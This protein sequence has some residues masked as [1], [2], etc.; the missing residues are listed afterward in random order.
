MGQRNPQRYRQGSSHAPARRADSGQAADKMGS[1]RRLVACSCIRH[2]LREFFQLTTPD[3]VDISVVTFPGDGGSDADNINRWRQQIGAAPTEE[4]RLSVVIPL[5]CRRKIFPR[6][7]SPETRRVCWPRGRGTTAEHGFSNSPV[8]A[9]AVEK[10][11]SNFVKFIQSV[12][13]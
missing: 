9:A 7:T 1:A 12:R 5:K 11:K 2:A 3:Q 13:F 4:C 6:S 10:E 8:R